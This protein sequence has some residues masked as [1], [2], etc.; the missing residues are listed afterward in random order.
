V[1]AKNGTVSVKKVDGDPGK[2]SVTSKKNKA[3]TVE[4]TFTVA[5]KPIADESGAS[6][7][8]MDDSK[9]VGKAD[10][11]KYYKSMEAFKTKFGDTGKGLV[12]S[13]DVSNGKGGTK[14][15]KLKAG[16]GKDYT[17]T[18]TP[19]GVKAKV[20]DIDV[21]KT[22]DTA[23]GSDGTKPVISNVVEYAIT[24]EGNYT[25]TV[26]GSIKVPL[27]TQVISGAG[28]VSG[29]ALTYAKLDRNIY[30]YIQVDNDAFANS[31]SSSGLTAETA[32]DILKI[33]GSSN[34]KVEKDGRIT[35]KKVDGNPAEVTVT[36]K[37]D[38]DVGHKISFTINKADISSDVALTI[39]TAPVVAKEYKDETVAKAAMEKVKISYEMPVAT[40]TGT[41]T[42]KLKA[43]KDYKITVSGD[44]SADGKKYTVSQVKIDAESESPYTGSI[45]KGAFELKLK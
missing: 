30:D 11:P 20:G 27:Y 37:K 22:T 42:V 13:Y 26:T 24:G 14:T 5:P 25:G 4:L 40:G 35:V 23:L 33:K 28:L 43:D 29:N 36:S 44:K 21:Y 17:I 12:A 38:K 18:A 31:T 45:T 2:I 39:D 1:D 34:I 9:A 16:S 8:T 19:M 3:A 41:K 7:L 15:I 32:K 6:V 10:K